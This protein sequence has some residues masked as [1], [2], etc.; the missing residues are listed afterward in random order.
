MSTPPRS[1]DERE[2]DRNALRVAWLL[3]S[4]WGKDGGEGAEEGL[5]WQAGRG[6]EGR[7]RRIFE[8][9]AFA[10]AHPLPPTQLAQPRAEATGSARQSSM[11]GRLLPARKEAIGSVGQNLARQVY[12]TYWKRRRQSKQLG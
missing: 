11:G 7:G 12:A 9:Y 3:V 8:E 2:A 6:W 4:G 1:E 10:S 5:D